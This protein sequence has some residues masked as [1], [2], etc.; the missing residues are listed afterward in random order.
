MGAK[1]YLL[2]PFSKDEL[3]HCIEAAV[4]DTDAAPANGHG[5][6]EIDRR[7][8]FRDSG[9]SRRQHLRTRTLKSAQIIYNNH[10]CLADCLMINTSEC[11]AALQLND[12][13]EYPSEFLLKVHRGPT[14]R[15]EVCWQRGNKLGVRFLDS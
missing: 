11:G 8:A 13:S 14:H 3:E 6:G 10:T 12:F 2:K 5:Q 15:C 9:R 1:Y 7:D 4:A